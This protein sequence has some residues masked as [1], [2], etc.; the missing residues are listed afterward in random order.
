MAFLIF[1]KEK[2]I[3]RCVFFTAVAACD[4][5]CIRSD[6]NLVSVAGSFET[7]DYSFKS[8][9][10]VEEIVVFYLIINLT[11]LYI[12]EI[13]DCYL[14]RN[15]HILRTKSGHLHYLFENLLHKKHNH[16]SGGL[17]FFHNT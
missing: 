5:I 4:Y 15:T 11:N 2:V 16:Q 8:W 6:G 12:I 10:C 14:I 17:S 3:A 7:P 9:H 1:I 13:E